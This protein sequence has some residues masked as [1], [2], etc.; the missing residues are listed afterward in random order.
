MRPGWSRPG[1]YPAAFTHATQA[2]GTVR[3]C[4]LTFPAGKIQSAFHPESQITP[5]AYDAKPIVTHSSLQFPVWGDESWTATKTRPQDLCPECGTF[6]R[7]QE[8]RT[9]YAWGGGDY[10]R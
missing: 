4:F 7:W 5:G 10:G 3:G 8:Q 9:G 1:H 2:F 6:V